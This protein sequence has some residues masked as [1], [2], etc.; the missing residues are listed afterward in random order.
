MRKN[1]IWRLRTYWQRTGG[2]LVEEFMMVKQDK[3]ANIA[4]RLL[5]GLIILGE[6]TQISTSRN[7]SIKNRDIIAV[8]VK[9]KRLGMNLMGQAYFSSMLLQKLQPR[10]IRTVAICSKSNLALKRLCLQHDIE[11]IVIT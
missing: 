6:K 11:V 5:D 8:Q 9:G 4:R 10:S 2:L 7:V 1:K 3:N